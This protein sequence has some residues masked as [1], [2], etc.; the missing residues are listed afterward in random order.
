MHTPRFRRLRERHRER[1]RSSERQFFEQN[2]QCIVPRRMRF[3]V[4]RGRFVQHQHI[5]PRGSGRGF[6]PRVGFAQSDGFRSF[7]IQLPRDGEY[8]RRK[9][10]CQRRD[11][12]GATV[13]RFVEHQAIRGAVAIDPVYA[14]RRR[15]GR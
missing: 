5:P 8:A 10:M 3:C 1:D 15:F 9:D 4:L 7:R 6:Q 11:G 12:V 14:P 2:R 13:W